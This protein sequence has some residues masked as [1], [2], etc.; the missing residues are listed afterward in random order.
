MQ[1]KS[2]VVT[3]VILV[4]V[5]QAGA[6]LQGIIMDSKSDVPLPGATIYNR[7][8]NMYRRST[9]DGKY[10]MPAKVGDTVFFSSAAY[11]KDTV[12]ISE[13]L[14]QSGF[15]IGLKSL[16]VML[17]TV[18]VNGRS[19]SDDSLERRNEYQKYYTKSPGL[20]G[21][22]TSKEGFGAS[23]SPISYFSKDQRE[24]RKFKKQLKYNEQQE[25]VDYRYSASFV[26]KLT[27]LQGDELAHF[28][29]SHRPSYKFVRKASQ[30]DL[31]NYVNTAYKSY[32]KEKPP[33]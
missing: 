6:Q 33:K 19:Y 13:D 23:V 9:A 8:K 7:S 5:M 1:W 14:L 31:L 18:Q 27:G 26:H 17:D 24:Q 10:S 15:D 21:G 3:V 25:Y 20:T 22:N 16:A 29:M 11:R 4:G 2:I 28:M 12:L 32:E 30:E